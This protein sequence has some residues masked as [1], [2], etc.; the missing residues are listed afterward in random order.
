MFLKEVAHSFDLVDRTELRADQDLLEP[1][2]L[3]SLD[4]A[5]RL[6]R[7]TDEIDRRQFRQLRALRTLLEVDRAIGEDGIGAAGLAIDFHSMLQVFP[8]AVPAG[9]GPAL[10]FLG[11]VGDPAGAA[12]G[13]DQDRRP[14]LA[15]RP[16]GQRAAIDRLAIPYPV[17]DFEVVLEGAEPVIVTVAEQLEIVARR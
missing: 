6:L 5:A 13:A 7:R 3:D 4:A 8:A 16:S 15:S 2:L 14:A 11:G 1:Q 12:P 9:R 10:G 17:H